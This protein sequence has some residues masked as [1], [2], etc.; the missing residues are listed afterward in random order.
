VAYWYVIRCC[1]F[2]STEVNELSSPLF[3]V[4]SILNMQAT[5][6]SSQINRAI[7]DLAEKNAR[8][9]RSMSI[10]ALISAI[11]LPAMFL[12]VGTQPDEPR[13]SLYANKHQ[14]IIRDKLLRL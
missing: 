5:E 8:E 7:R 14:D 6:S 11:F 4:Q 1:Y 2:L 3:Q 9:T 10:V 12:A 13:E